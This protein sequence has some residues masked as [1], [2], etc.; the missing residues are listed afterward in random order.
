MEIPSELIERSCWVAHLTTGAT[1]LAHLGPPHAGWAR[2]NLIATSQMAHLTHMSAYSRRDSWLPTR[3]DI[4]TR[5]P[6]RRYEVVG[7]EV[8]AGMRSSFAKCS[9][10]F[11][12][13]AVWVGPLR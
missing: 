12:I 6:T 3:R 4:F 2:A 11:R 7:V 1:W 10:E 13:H 9:M 5:R 8:Q